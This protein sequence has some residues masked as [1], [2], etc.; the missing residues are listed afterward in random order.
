M[1]KIIMSL[2]LMLISVS[3][4]GSTISGNV[5]KVFDMGEGD[6]VVTIRIQEKNKTTP[7]LIYLKDDNKNYEQIYN[8]LKQAEQSALEESIPVQFN[9]NLKAD[10]K[11]AVIET[12]SKG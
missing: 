4:Y 2:V 7:T 5:T 9:F 3:G 8:V 1:K 10:P 12:V 6:H 11:L